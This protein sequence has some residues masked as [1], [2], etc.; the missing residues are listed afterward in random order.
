MAPKETGHAIC[1]YYTKTV[2][3][4]AITISTGSCVNAGF[5]MCC[6]PA[7]EICGLNGCFCDQFCYVAGDCCFDIQAINCFPGKLY[8]I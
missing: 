1:S 3:T 6:D 4:V 2:C 5:T 7:I 8:I